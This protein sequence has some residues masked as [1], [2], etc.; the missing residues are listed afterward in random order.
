MLLAAGPWPM[1]HAAPVT[2]RAAPTGSA[3][4]SGPTN[5]S[6]HSTVDKF[7]LSYLEWLPAGYSSHS[8]YPL[9]VYLHGMG[10]SFTWV[11]GGIGGNSVPTSFPSATSSAKAILISLN[12][13]S[14]AGFYSDTPCGGP[15]EQDVLD[16]IA[17]EQSTRR[18]GELYLTGFSMGSVGAFR[19]AADHAGLVTGIGV[20][21]TLSDV[22]EEYDYSSGISTLVDDLCGTAPRASNA[23]AVATLT[24]M[25]PARF[26]PT[27]FA[28]VRMYVVA[29]GHDHAIPNNLSIW[30]YLQAGAVMD[31]RSCL[32]DSAIGEPSTCTTP[33]ATLHQSSHT[34][35]EFRYVFEPT[36]LHS[37]IQFDASDL[38]GFLLGNLATG[39]YVADFP[40]TK[41]TVAP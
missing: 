11:S 8:T 41:V 22:F 1:G 7:A 38:F 21:G 5:V 39:F 13:R 10:T 24:A 20:A 14:A 36:G 19:I 34:K 2:G 28:N 40:P 16:A 6:Y 30:P 18:I 23:T 9:V 17:H 26:S 15:Q 32:N 3:S 33:F 31:S 27:S 29:G 37:N 12:T 4:A 25:S 35:Y